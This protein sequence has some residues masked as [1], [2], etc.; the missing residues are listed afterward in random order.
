[1]F[2]KNRLWFIREQQRGCYRN[3]LFFYQRLLS[4]IL[5]RLCARYNIANEFLYDFRF[6]YK[7][8]A[9]ICQIALKGVNALRVLQPPPEISSILRKAR[10]TATQIRNIVGGKRYPDCLVHDNMKQESRK[11]TCNKLVLKFRTQRKIVNET[12][13]ESIRGFLIGEPTPR[14]FFLRPALILVN[15]NVKLTAVR[16]GECRNIFG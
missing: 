2:W 9:C 15:S 14:S 10:G 3:F 6:C 8:L 13:Q 11:I 16:I 5:L 12:L 1:M 7:Q 4:Q